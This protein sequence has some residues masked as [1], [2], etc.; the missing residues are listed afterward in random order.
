MREYDDYHEE[1]IRLYT[2]V[3]QRVI[4]LAAV[5]IAVPVM[6]WTITTFVRSYVARP[7][8]PALEHVA[9]TVA[10]TNMP[11]RIPTITLSPPSSAPSPPDQSAPQRI[12]EASVSDT[13]PT[14]ETTSGGPNLASL[15]NASAP[16]TVA[17]GPSGTSL[18]AMRTS[19]S[20]ITATASTTG[21]IS[22]TANAPPTAP[23]PRLSP[24]PRSGDN[25]P[26]IGAPSSSDRDR[27]IAW[28]NPNT[29]SPPD[30]AAPR[31]APPAPPAP[32]A[33]TAAAEV[34]PANE[35]IR[36]PVPLPRQ[37]PGIFAVAAAATGPVPLPRARPA[38]APAE[39]A[40][41]VIEPASGYRPGLDSDR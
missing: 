16:P 15:P 1:N 2:P 20:A 36:G 23:A 13:S 12:D 39:A 10:S 4:I 21:D 26:S 37:R 22:T 30:F 41:S 31:L 27:S 6:M 8:L 11:A 5:I 35:P 32:P 19:S 25:A 33:R 14:A 29:T 18:Q 24:A 34:L 38:D 3:L 7:K 17:N 40:N 9:S 28:P